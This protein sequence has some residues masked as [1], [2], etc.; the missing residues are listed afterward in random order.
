ML[1]SVVVVAYSV[2]VYYIHLFYIMKLNERGFDVLRTCTLGEE[3]RNLANW[4]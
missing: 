4:L 1:L 2:H 3:I